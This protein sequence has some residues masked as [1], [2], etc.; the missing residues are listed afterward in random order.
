[1]L[2]DRPQILVEG[3]YPAHSPEW[4]REYRKRRRAESAEQIQTQDA[5]RQRR[6]RDSQIE[7]LYEFMWDEV[8]QPDGVRLW[9]EYQLLC[10]LSRYPDDIQRYLPTMTPA[11]IK[12]LRREH[13]LNRF[14]ERNVLEFG[15]V[16]GI[17]PEDSDRADDY[18]APDFQGDPAEISR[19]FIDGKRTFAFNDEINHRR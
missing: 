15:R 18:I 14:G 10:F 6:H 19:P 4:W 12:R 13:P 1:M 5:E 17:A 11:E 7:R 16:Y 9:D 2:R 8:P 3:N